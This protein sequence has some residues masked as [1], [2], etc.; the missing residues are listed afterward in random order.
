MTQVAEREEAEG[1]RRVNKSTGRVINTP[2]VVKKE[3]KK[4]LLSPGGF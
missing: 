2:K 1:A 4:G 3:M